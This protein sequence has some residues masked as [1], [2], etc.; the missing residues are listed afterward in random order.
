MCYMV[1][2]K[3]S[4]QYRS[5]LLIKLFCGMVNVLVCHFDF[6]VP[7]SFFYIHEWRFGFD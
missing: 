3:H 4:I 1:K 6:C 7:E 5:T 2:L